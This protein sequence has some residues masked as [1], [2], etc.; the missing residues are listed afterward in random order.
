M[1]VQTLTERKAAAIA[2][3]LAAL[4]T[5]RPALAERARALGGRFLLYG[6]AARGELR[7]DSD[8][9]LLLD[10]PDAAAMSAAWDFAETECARLGLEYDILPIGMCNARF[11]AHVLPEAI[12]LPSPLSGS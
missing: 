8:V 1:A 7:Y 6:S 9:D 3:K 12:S 5:L 4:A 10:F 2:A 11:L